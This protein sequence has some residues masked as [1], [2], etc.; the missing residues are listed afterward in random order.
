MTT[1]AYPITSRSLRHVCTLQTYT[2]TGT[3][4]RGQ[5]TGSWGD[6]AE[7]RCRIK[8]LGGRNAEYANQLYAAAT[9]EILMRYR[10]D[11]TRTNRLVLGSRIFTIG[12]VQ[13][14]DELDR[15]LRLM[16]KEER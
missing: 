9:H 3:D 11:V 6:T 10:S 15:W 4:G 8:P 16:V 5:P 2:S 12:S 13:S 14:V 1:D 7:V